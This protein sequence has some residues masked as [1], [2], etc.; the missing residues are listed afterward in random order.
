M[1]R[2]EPTSVGVTGCVATA[3][4]RGAAFALLTNAM[5]HN[6]TIA[7]ARLTPRYLFMAISPWV[8]AY[9]RYDTLSQ[10]I[11]AA[12]KKQA[13]IAGLFDHVRSWL[14]HELQPVSSLPVTV[15]MVMMVVIVIMVMMV[16]MVIMVMVP[17]MLLTMA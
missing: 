11:R 14:C 3:P 7:A 17:P 2:A 15:M 12:S 5:P 13:R 1:L 4:K 10:E 8:D 9:C 16:M 6:A